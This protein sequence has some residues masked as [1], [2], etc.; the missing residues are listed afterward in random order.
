MYSIEEIL[1]A[2][3]I[4]LNKKSST[5]K[6]ENKVTINEFVKPIKKKLSIDEKKQ[7]YQE[8]N[9]LFNLFIQSTAKSIVKNN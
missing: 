9:K 4:L 6:S 3:N 5:E 1:E 7:F 8:I 2:T